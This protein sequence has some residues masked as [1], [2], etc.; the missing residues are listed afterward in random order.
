MANE[1]YNKWKSRRWLIC[2]YWMLVVVVALFGNK[3]LGLG[4]DLSLQHTILAA[5]T[6]YFLLFTGY[7]TYRKVQENK[8][9]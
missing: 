1:L 2:F 6:A 7:E 9:A 8:N 5:A 3:V 4:I